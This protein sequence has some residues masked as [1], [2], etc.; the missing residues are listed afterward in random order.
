[1][2][3]LREVN[4]HILI[5]SHCLQLRILRWMNGTIFHLEPSGLIS[6]GLIGNWNMWGWR[7]ICRYHC[8]TLK[9]RGNRIHI[10]SAMVCFCQIKTIKISR[11]WNSSK[12]TPLI[13]NCQVGLP[14]LTWSYSCRFFSPLLGCLP[15]QYNI[16]NSWKL[17]NNFS[18]WY[19]TAWDWCRFSENPGPT[20]PFV[21]SSYYKVKSLP[22]SEDWDLI[23][24]GEWGGLW[25]WIP[26]SGGDT[27]GV[28]TTIARCCHYNC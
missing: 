28:V 1:M 14:T 7:K 22:K 23:E 16:G 24:V 12:Q 6:V 15:T 8:F 13:L 3:F 10:C 9:P 11:G 20:W 26:P 5:C 2:K 17:W 18:N 4:L 19:R 21:W 27:T 25:N